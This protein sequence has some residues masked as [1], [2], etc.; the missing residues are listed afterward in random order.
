[1][2]FAR[3]VTRGGK[4]KLEGITKSVDFHTVG[5]LIEGPDD[6]P[7]DEP[8]DEPVRVKS[9]FL[10]LPKIPESSK[11]VFDFISG[12]VVEAKNVVLYTQ[13]EEACNR[14]TTI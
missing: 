7:D 13:G 8:V 11:A 1:M 6:E 14:D 5:E 12:G 9:Q 3:L 2:L 4:K 10:L